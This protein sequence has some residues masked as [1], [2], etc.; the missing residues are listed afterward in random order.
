MTPVKDC[1]D[2]SLQRSNGGY[3]VPAAPLATLPTTMALSGKVKTALDETRTLILAP[4]FC[5]VFS[6]RV[7]SGRVSMSCPRPAGT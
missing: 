2:R 6:T 4:R 5:L 1:I 7:L 3:C